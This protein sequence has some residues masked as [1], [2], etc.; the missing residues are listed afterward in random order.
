MPAVAAR[1]GRS[2]WWVYEEA[3][4]CRLP[5]RKR[6]GTLLFLE[7]ELDAADDGA[8]LEVKRLPNGGRVVRPKVSA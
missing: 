7:H 3:R 6:G 2:P 4:F 5:H 8:C 1:Y